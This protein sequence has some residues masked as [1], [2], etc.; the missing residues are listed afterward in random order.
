[1]PLSIC[2]DTIDS[3][4]ERLVLCD[5]MYPKCV[6]NEQGMIQHEHT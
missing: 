2:S 5:A 6:D 1:M 3:Q 4:A